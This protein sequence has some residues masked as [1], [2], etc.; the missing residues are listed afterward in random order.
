MILHLKGCHVIF[1]LGKNISF[2]ALFDEYV[3]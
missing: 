2:T 3:A 1:D